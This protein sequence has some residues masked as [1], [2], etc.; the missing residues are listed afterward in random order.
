M[1][2][3]LKRE[4]LASL[5]MVLSEIANNTTESFDKRFIFG[6]HRNLEYFKPEIESIK[7]TQKEPKRFQ[8]FQEKIQQIGMESA[9]KDEQGNPK[10]ENKNGNRVFVITEKKEE[11]NKRLLALRQEYNDVIEEQ[12]KNM[13]QFEELMQEEIEFD[14]CQVSFNNFPNS[15]DIT[16]HNVLKHMI[17]E[18][19]EQIEAML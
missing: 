19:P 2:L 13:K 16:K 15:Y 4:E 17:K 9:D 12:Q 11:A 1:K 14:I 10:L 5:N 3:K 18:T 7:N 6:V 8:E